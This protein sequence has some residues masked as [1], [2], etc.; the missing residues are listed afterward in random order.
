MCQ[1]KGSVLTAASSASVHGLCFRRAR[2]GGLNS[3]AMALDV[4]TSVACA[5]ARPPSRGHL[6]LFSSSRRRFTFSRQFHLAYSSS[7]CSKF[8]KAAFLRTAL[9]RCHP[10][11]PSVFQTSPDAHRVGLERSS[12]GPKSRLKAS[13]RPCRHMVLHLSLTFTYVRPGIFF[14]IA[15]HLPTPNF[16]TPR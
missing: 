3:P 15:F 10:S 1:Q 6:L 8:K 5:R 16:C 14:V 2:G 4:G 13:V 12:G 9:S 7:R 11:A